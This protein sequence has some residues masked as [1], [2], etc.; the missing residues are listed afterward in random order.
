M[1]LNRTLAR[2][3]ACLLACLV[4]PLEAKLLDI[5]V[6]DGLTGELDD[7][8]LDDENGAV[9]LDDAAVSTTVPTDV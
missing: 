1:R 4:A 5:N 8:A 3:V 7:A 6:R 2:L 9:A